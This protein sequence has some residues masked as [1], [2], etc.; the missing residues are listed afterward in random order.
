MIMDTLTSKLNFNWSDIL[1]KAFTSM[2]KKKAQSP[3]IAIPMYYKLDQMK[4]KLMDVFK[5]HKIKLI[6]WNTIEAYINKNDNYFW[7]VGGQDWER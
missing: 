6:N 1:F 2:V 4:F 5:L 7:E 3:E